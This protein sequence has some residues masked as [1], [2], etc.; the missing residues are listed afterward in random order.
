MSKFF[1]NRFRKGSATGQ[2]TDRQES[3]PSKLPSSRQPVD[4]Q[5][6]L[7]TPTIEKDGSLFDGMDFGAED[8]VETPMPDESPDLISSALP[9]DLKFEVSAPPPVPPISSSPPLLREEVETATPSNP[10]SADLGSQKKKTRKAK[11][12]WG[13]FPPS[14]SSHSLNST[15]TPRES[16]PLPSEPEPAG[17]SMGES[18]ALKKTDTDIRESVEKLLEI[19]SEMEE[20]RRA[21][22]LSIE[23][24]VRQLTARCELQSRR[25]ELNQLIGEAEEQEDFT[26]AE[27]LNSEL[28]GTE[29]ELR[30]CDVRTSLLDVWNGFYSDV[31]KVYKR[32]AGRLEEMSGVRQDAADRLEHERR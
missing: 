16:S 31:M 22:E 19:M 8:S 6:D 26:T 18:G 7:G 10:L 15:P 2:N 29:R 20:S 27:R 5:F 28:E 21:G 3:D 32:E 25:R 9:S 17:M 11:L 13:V 4:T 14:G 1:Q 12:P 23:K 24:R 30:E